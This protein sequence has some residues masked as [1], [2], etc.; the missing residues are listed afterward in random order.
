MLFEIKLL[1]TKFLLAIFLL[2]RVCQKRIIFLQKKNTNVAKCNLGKV[3]IK[4]SAGQRCPHGR[5]MRGQQPHFTG[6]PG[7]LQLTCLCQFIS[8][9]FTCRSLCCLSSLTSH[10]LVS[11]VCGGCGKYFYLYTFCFISTDLSV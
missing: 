11:M 6:A 10:P 1:L 4:A 2:K 9:L 5:D 8:H 3:N 7:F